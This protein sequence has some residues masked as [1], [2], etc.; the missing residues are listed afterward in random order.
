MLVDQSEESLYEIIATKIAELTKIDRVIDMI[1]RV[2][3][4]S[5]TRERALP[6]DLDREYRSS[7]LK[8]PS[9]CGKNPLHDPPILVACCVF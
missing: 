7:T 6:C 1:A 8:H 4:A 3:V 9:P 2:G 5:G